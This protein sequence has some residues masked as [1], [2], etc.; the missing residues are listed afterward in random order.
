ME[1]KTESFPVVQLNHDL[2][3]KVLTEYAHINS[4][5]PFKDRLEV[6]DVIYD[7]E[8][9]LLTAFVNITQETQH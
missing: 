9:E 5:I 1:P 7:E 8:E 6:V 3:G 2:L 4:H